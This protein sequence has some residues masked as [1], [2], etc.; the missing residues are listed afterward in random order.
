MSSVLINAEAIGINSRDCE[1][2]SVGYICSVVGGSDVDDLIGRNVFID[3]DVRAN[4]G[5]TPL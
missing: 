2:D 5:G 4:G 1:G 3:N